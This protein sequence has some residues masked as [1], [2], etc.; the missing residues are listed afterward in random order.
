MLQSPKRLL[1]LSVLSLAL[2]SGCCKRAVVTPPVSPVVEVLRSCLTPAIL[3]ARPAPIAT[4][5]TTCL[6]Q[7]NDA[8]D[9]L[10]NGNEV[11]DAYITRLIANCRGGDGDR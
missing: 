5:L 1:R 2:L 8:M 10:A 11:R 6:S 7:G 4:T 9:C 3:A